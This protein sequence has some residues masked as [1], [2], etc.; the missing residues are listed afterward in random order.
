M[1]LIL[2][3]HSDRSV[4]VG[5]C[6]P[7]CYEQVRSQWL[8]PKCCLKGLQDSPENW[9]A[10]ATKVVSESWTSQPLPPL[11]PLKSG[12]ATVWDPSEKCF[13]WPVQVK[14]EYRTYLFSQENLFWSQKN[15]ENIW[16]R[17]SV[18]FYIGVGVC[19]GKHTASCWRRMTDPRIE[20]PPFCGGWVVPGGGSVYG[21][22]RL[23]GCRFGFFCDHSNEHGAP[24]NAFWVVPGTKLRSPNG[25][26]FLIRPMFS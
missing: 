23:C 3:S 15:S 10:P 25:G 4:G 5:T 8:S 6:Q 17:F 26:V 2:L 16:A 11:S 20:P 21:N 19:S 1:N 14:T 12:C 22:R 18:A 13:W 7:H 9:P 24:E